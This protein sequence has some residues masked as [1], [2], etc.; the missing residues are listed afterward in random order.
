M[1]KKKWDSDTKVSPCD[2]FKYQSIA[3]HSE[4]GRDDTFIGKESQRVMIGLPLKAFSLR[5]LFQNTCFPLSRM[6]ELYVAPESCKSAM[7][8]EMFR[9]HVSAGGGYLLN[10]AEPRDSPDLRSSI[11]GHE[12]DTI[13]PTVTCNSVEDWQQSITEWLKKSRTTF[14]ESGSCPFP[15]AIGVD[16]ITGVT[17]RSDITDIWEKGHASIGYAKSANIINT[18]CKFVFSELRVWPYSF[19]GVNHMKV[20]KDA[21]GFLE[22]KI[23]GGQALDF[24]ATFKIRMHKKGDI[25]RLDESGRLIE[26]TMEKNSL[27]TA[28]ERRSIDVPMKWNF[29]EN[30]VQAT[31]W[32]WNEASL[33][34]INELTGVRK[35]R[36]LEVTGIRNLSKSTRTGDSPKLG[37]VKASW[38]ELGA[39]IEENEE[40]VKE[41]NVIHGIRERKPFEA[42]VPYSVQMAD[43][44]DSA[45]L[46]VHLL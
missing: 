32:D 11:I 28:G 36:I 9:W 6:T 14:S 7:L 4:L 8:Y 21:R 20:S 26:L 37:L 44:K 18:Y 17:T 43:A 24:Y 33:A 45:D 35:N 42:G 3:A 13:F 23:P 46:D 5:Y 12:A 41:L 10:L 25:D 39:A 2:F 40:M 34:L 16:S 31:W 30:G 38:S 19:I 29:A 1:A 15:A 27:G 22:R